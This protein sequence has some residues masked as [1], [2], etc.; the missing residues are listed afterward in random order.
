MEALHSIEERVQVLNVSV[1]DVITIL[2]VNDGQL[3][4]YFSFRRY[5][6]C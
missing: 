4:A 6:C 1:V 2:L 3:K 5:L